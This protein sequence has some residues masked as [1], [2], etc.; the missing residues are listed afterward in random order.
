MSRVRPISEVTII[1]AE[2]DAQS[3]ISCAAKAMR[4]RNRILGEAYGRD[5]EFFAF[6]R[7]LKA[8]EQSM[9]GNNTTMV[10]SPDSPFFKYFQNGQ[11]GRR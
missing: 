5:P 3:P 4:E 2:R 9:T 10:I 1:K 7:S 8:Y 11:S 6:Y